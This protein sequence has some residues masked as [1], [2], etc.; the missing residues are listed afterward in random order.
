MDN[1]E[2]TTENTIT[3]DNEVINVDTLS[4]ESK[5]YLEHIIDIQKQ[6]NQLTFKTQQ[7]NT[8]KSAFLSM[9]NNSKQKE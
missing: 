3:I 7:L 5:L 8:A 4:D 9:F 1:K 6:L 2:L